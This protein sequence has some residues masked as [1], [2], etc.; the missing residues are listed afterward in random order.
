MWNNKINGFVCVSR[1]TLMRFLLKTARNDA[2]DTQKD[3]KQIPYSNQ[4]I[5][6]KV[7][8]ILSTGLD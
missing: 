8:H 6:N 7:K 3:S 1:E 4:I 2:I 5:Y